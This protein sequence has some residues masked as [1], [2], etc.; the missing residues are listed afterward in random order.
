MFEAWEARRDGS[1][2]SRPCWSRPRRRATPAHS[3]A[4]V[5]TVASAN[6]E[7]PG[8]TAATNGAATAAIDPVTTVVA[9]GVTAVVATA[10]AAAGATG[11]A[12]A[13]AVGAIAA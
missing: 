6:G 7:A 4:R 5:G 1:D 11:A 9:A 10:A 13:A 2:W 3:M 8:V 12:A